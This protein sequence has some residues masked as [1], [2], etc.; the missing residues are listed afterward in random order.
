MGKTGQGAS[1][2]KFPIAIPEDESKPPSF[3][4]HIL[5]LFIAYEE[6]LIDGQCLTCNVVVVQCYMDSNQ[7]YMEFWS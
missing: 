3:S 6:E 5:I 4:F 7:S 2:I 1:D